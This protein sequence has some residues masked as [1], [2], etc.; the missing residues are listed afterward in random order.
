VTDKVQRKERITR[1]TPPREDEGGAALKTRQEENGPEEK[2]ALRS[3]GEDGLRK[4]FAFNDL[5]FES[6]KVF[7]VGRALINGGTRT[8]QG[9]PTPTHD[10]KELV[11][12]GGL[13]RFTTKRK[14]LVA[15]NVKAR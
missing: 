13:P 12:L 9:P 14:R 4:A 8:Q 6:A 2:G 7:R 10:R 5:V 1:E 11:G 15:T 3:G